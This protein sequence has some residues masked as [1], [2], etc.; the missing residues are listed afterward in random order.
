VVIEYNAN[1]PLDRRL[2]MPRDDRHSWDGTDYVGASL[3]A[4]RSLG[5]RKGYE[6]VHTDS[7]GVNAFFVRREETA[8]LPTG[9]EVPLHRANYFRAGIALRRDPHG[10]RF[11]DL[12]DERLVRR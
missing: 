9:A 12:D 5:E 3:G 2:V 10:R 8:S 7:T 11:Y 1:L 6:L 4:L